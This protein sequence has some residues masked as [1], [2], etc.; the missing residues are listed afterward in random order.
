MNKN[1]LVLTIVAGLILAGAASACDA[2]DFPFNG[3][4]QSIKIEET[5]QGN[6]ISLNKAEI[7]AI[8]LSG[9]STPNLLRVKIFG[10]EYKV[11]FSTSTNITP[12]FWG[13]PDQNLSEFS[14]GDFVNVEGILDSADFF[15]IQAKTVWN[16]S[17][18]TISGQKK[19]SVLSGTI[20]SIASSTNSFN[21][22]TQNA[23]SLTV[24]TDS[25]TKIYQGKNLKAFSDLQTGMKVSVRGAWD[26][27]L[28]KIQA[29]LIRIK[30][31]KTSNP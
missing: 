28:A 14:V 15:L 8:S 12:H 11:Q 19:Q 23:S 24:N 4:K 3:L 2:F 6:R 31:N 26:K 27:T 1:P 20:Q 30:P 29:L 13:K 16:I 5:A 9:T 22:Q 17:R 18:W 25:N 10:Q 7:T 21:L